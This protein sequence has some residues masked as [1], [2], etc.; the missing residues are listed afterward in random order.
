MLALFLHSRFSSGGVGL[1]GH[2][3]RRGR[4]AGSEDDLSKYLGTYL[5]THAQS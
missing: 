5:L 1:C 4:E 3:G 2:E